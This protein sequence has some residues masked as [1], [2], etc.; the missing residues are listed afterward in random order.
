MS[1]ILELGHMRPETLQMVTSTSKQKYK[2][3][4][5]RVQ[6]CDV[7]STFFQCSISGVFAAL[8][9]SGP[10]CQLCHLQPSVAQTAR[11][12]MY[13]GLKAEKSIWHF[14][15]A[16]RICRSLAPAVTALAFRI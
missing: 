16:G 7:S 14:G 8:W 11:Y 6:Y 2:E 15:F 13:E 9:A 10:Y 1:A 3:T 4:K 5:K 12:M